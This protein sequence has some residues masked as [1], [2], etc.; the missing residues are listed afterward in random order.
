MNLTFTFK[1]R[2]ISVPNIMNTFLNFPN[3][4]RR[5]ITFEY[6]SDVPFPIHILP[7]FLYSSSVTPN[8][9][10]KI[11]G[12]LGEFLKSRENDGSVIFL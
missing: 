1:L 7:V 6:R 8:E 2:D 4:F 5:K 11:W 9:S 12:V 3:S 10:S